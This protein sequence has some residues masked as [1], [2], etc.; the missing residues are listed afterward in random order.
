MALGVLW[1]DVNRKPKIWY[2]KKIPIPN[3]YLVFP[4]PPAVRKW[5]RPPAVRGL[6]PLFHPIAAL[7]TDVQSCTKLPVFTTYQCTD[8]TLKLMEGGLTGSTARCGPRGICRSQVSSIAFA[9]IGLAGLSSS[10]KNSGQLPVAAGK[11]PEPNHPGGDGRKP[12]RR[13]GRDRQF[14]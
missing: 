8:G 5:L 7:F 10:C 4:P 2:T 14:S 9:G 11:E 1:G 13:R 6:T 3:R 12:G